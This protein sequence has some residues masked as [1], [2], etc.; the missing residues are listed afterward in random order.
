MILETGTFLTANHDDS[1]NLE[2]FKVKSKVK[3]NG[4]LV[5]INAPRPAE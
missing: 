5:K 1:S 3:D 2:M 4:H